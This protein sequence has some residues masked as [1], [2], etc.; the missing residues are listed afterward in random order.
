[1]KTNSYKM[2]AA[3][4][5]TLS[6]LF[7]GCKTTVKNYQS[8]YDVAVQRRLRE[9]SLRE[10]RR[11]EMGL[12]NVVMEE[13]ADGARLTRVGDRELP[14]LHVTY[15]KAD[16]VRRYAPAASYFKM[17]ANAASYAEEL[18]AAGWELSRVAKSA[19]RYYVLLGDFD[20]AAPALTLLDAYLA[21]PRRLPSVGLTAPLLTLTP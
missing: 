16:S 17:P 15:A 18:R 1:M 10:A 12:E 2:G 11:A 14:V 9:D 5:I 6:L 21:S 19:D 3:A 7:G 20:E 8:A 13:S 4:M